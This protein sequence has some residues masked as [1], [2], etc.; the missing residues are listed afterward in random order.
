MIEALLHGKLS[1]EQENME[2]ILTSNVFGVFQFAAP[3][4]GLFRFLAKAKTV[5]DDCPFAIFDSGQIR[6]ACVRYDFW[7][8]WSRCEPDVVVNIQA[9]DLS[10][11]VCIEA[12]YRSGKS[13]QADEI[14]ERPNDQLA[15]EWLQLAAEAEK[16]QAVPV[17]IYLTADVGC[18]R[19]QISDS[20]LELSRKATTGASTPVICWL[21]WRELPELFAGDSE[22]MLESAARLA[23]RMELVFFQGIAP[24]PPIGADWAFHGPA[25][26]WCFQLPEITNQWRFTS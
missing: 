20:L 22:K 13:S 6:K 5:E 18:P 7:P 9:G 2:D 3:E 12:K 1:R 10:C 17:L 14:E 16:K 19:S 4:T 25:P 26:A 23:S 15:K 24:V 21:S 8:K 11:L